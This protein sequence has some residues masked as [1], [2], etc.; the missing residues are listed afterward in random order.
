MHSRSIGQYRYTGLLDDSRRGCKG[1][2][3]RKERGG[4]LPTGFRFPVSTVYRPLNRSSLLSALSNRFYPGG[5][6]YRRGAAILT[7]RGNSRG[8]SRS[9]GNEDWRTATP[10]R[11]GR[12]KQNRN[13]VYSERK[14]SGVVR[15]FMVYCNFFFFFFQIFP[16]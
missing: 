16:S 2:R 9:V 12:K 13:P 5:L 10:G 3:G 8:G 6:C 15:T 11:R 14:F 1:K 7:V 4:S